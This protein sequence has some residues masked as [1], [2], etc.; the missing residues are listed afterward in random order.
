VDVGRKQFLLAKLN[1]Q[2]TR[3]ESQRTNREASASPKVPIG[4]GLEFGSMVNICESPINV[5]ISNK[6][7]AQASS[8]SQKAKQ[9]GELRAGIKSDHASSEV[10][11]LFTQQT[12]PII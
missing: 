3:G 2:Y 10:N 4:R 6:L 5:V 7:K 11:T 9:W 1:Q 8:L 12:Y